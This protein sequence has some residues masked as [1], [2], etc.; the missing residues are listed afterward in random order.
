MNMRTPDRAFQHRPEGFQPVH[1]NVATGVFLGPVVDRF[2][3]IAKGLEDAISAPFIAA[4]ARS[5]GH[6]LEDQRDKR[7]T[8]GVGNNPR[9]NLAVALKDTEHNRLTFGTA[10]REARNLAPPTANVGLST[11]T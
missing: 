7:L 10:P 2:M 11:S 4:N 3:L 6:V 5:L 9:I 8:T 1:M